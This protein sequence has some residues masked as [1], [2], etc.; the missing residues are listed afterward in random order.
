MAEKPPRWE[1]E[2]GIL[3]L[4]NWRGSP[5]GKE[6]KLGGLPEVRKKGRSLVFLGGRRPKKRA[7]AAPGR[8]RTKRA[9]RKEKEG[10]KNT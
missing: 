10:V 4:F 3:W 1:E 9:W 5:V 2:K 6:K 7:L 8:N